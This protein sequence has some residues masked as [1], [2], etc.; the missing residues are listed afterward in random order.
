MM[1]SS[2]A[3]G[4]AYRLYR[5]LSTAERSQSK[6][7]ATVF[8]G[9]NRRVFVDGKGMYPKRTEGGDVTHLSRRVLL[10][11]GGAGGKGQHGGEQEHAGG[12]GVEDRVGAGHVT[13]PAAEERAQDAGDPKGGE[14]QAVIH[15][16]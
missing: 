9:R 12:N 16:E 4:T 10:V 5:I 14:D 7:A 11:L 13:D 8:I 15:T 6:R 2:G 3:L 1:T